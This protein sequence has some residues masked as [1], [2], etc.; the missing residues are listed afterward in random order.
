LGIKTRIMKTNKK[1]LLMV[2]ASI[3]ATFLPFLT[4][5]QGGPGGDPDVLPVDGGIT[6]LAAAGVA[7]SVKKIKEYRKKKHDADQAK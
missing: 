6:I 2:V 3:T 1:R 4:F 7:Y 5:A